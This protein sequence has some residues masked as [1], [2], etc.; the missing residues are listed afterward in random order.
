MWRRKDLRECLQ[1]ISYR[2]EYGIEDTRQALLEAH[3]DGIHPF[4]ITIDDRAGSNLPHMYGAVNYVVI[5][6]VKKNTA[7]SVGHL[8]PPDY[9]AACWIYSIVASKRRFEIDLSIV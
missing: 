7:K 1:S 9:L 8:P 5:D 4:C 6:D 2:G 3:C